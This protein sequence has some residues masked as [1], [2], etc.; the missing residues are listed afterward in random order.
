MTSRPNEIE[1]YTNRYF[2][3]PVSRRLAAV[4]AR[5]DVHPNA[6]SF[7]GIVFGL[8]AAVA[9]YHFAREGAA[10]IGFGC[11]LVWHVLDGTDGQ[12]ARLSGKATTAG[13]VIDGFAD[14]SVFLAVYVALGL[15]SA[16]TLAVPIGWLVVLAATSHVLQA[17]ALERERE[18]Y[19]FWVYSGQAGKQPGRGPMPS[20]PIL[21]WLY[22]GYL[23][24]QNFLDSV[25]RVK[26][27]G[28]DLELGPH[29]RALAA[30]KY[31]DL[32]SRHIRRWWVLSANTHTVAI[33]IFAFLGQPEW[34][35]VFDATVLNAVLLV[36]LWDKRRRDKTFMAWLEKLESRTPGQQRS[37]A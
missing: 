1:E 12:L 9:Y 4:L 18:T 25:E 23:R 15:A 19:V 13:K 3:H 20:N 10:L 6:V 36:L 30:E 7:A 21:Y 33:F 34:Y 35:F 37:K 29:R 16:G 5:L 17:A 27:H 26:Q 11:M 24:V 8:S 32:Y 14:Y 22:F 31:R 28:F 2:V